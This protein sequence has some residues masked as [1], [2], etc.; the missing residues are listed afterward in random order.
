M[1]GSLCQRVQDLDHLRVEA[2]RALHE[3]L[4]HDLDLCFTFLSLARHEKLGADL[5][6]LVQNA[7]KGLATIRHFEGHIS[8]PLAWL[9]IQ[10]RAD[11][12]EGLLRSFSE[13]NA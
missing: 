13:S 11:E 12:L 3:F 8:D 5:Q 1:V 2:Q 9:R 7:I 6:Q 4:I 10:E